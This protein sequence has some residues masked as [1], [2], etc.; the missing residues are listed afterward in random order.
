MIKTC[1][2]SHIFISGLLN[3]NANANTIKL[4]NLTY[5]DYLIEDDIYKQR[6]QK[7]TNS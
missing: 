3:A 7:H 5:V 6:K 1:P 2:F 4:N